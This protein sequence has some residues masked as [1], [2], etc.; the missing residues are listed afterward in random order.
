MSNQLEQRPRAEWG[1]CNGRQFACGRIDGKSGNAERTVGTN[2]KKFLGGRQRQRNRA[3]VCAQRHI[4]TRPQHGAVH[5]ERRYRAVLVVGN[6]DESRLWR[7]SSAKD[8]RAGSHE[9]DRQKTE[10]E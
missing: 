7:Q 3:A 5:E 9:V 10:K 8:E 2:V 1:T 4:S 6:I